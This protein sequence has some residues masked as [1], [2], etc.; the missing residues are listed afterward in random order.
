M[1]TFLEQAIRAH[2]RDYVAGRLSLHD[3][4]AWLWSATQDIED[5]DDSVV[6][7]LTYEIVLRLA[8]Y[9]KGHRG[10]PDVKRLLAP[11]TAPDPVPARR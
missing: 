6:R 10:E 4:D 5:A 8:E 11:L 9:A 3:L 1:A 2:V 7:D